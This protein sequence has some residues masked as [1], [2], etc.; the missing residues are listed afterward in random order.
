MRRTYTLA[1]GSAATEAAV[2]TLVRSSG[3]IVTG[4]QGLAVEL[5]YTMLSTVHA[6]QVGVQISLYVWYVA[7][8][9]VEKV[10]QVYGA[11]LPFRL[12]GCPA[13]GVYSRHDW[14]VESYTSLSSVAAF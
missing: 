6:S 4:R 14:P 3:R 2:P 5:R 1:S 7:A 9:L 13:G 11:E 12:P 10:G 8:K